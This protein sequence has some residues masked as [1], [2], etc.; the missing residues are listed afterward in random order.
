LLIF[1]RGPEG[2]RIDYTARYQNQAESIVLDVPEITKAFSVVALGIGTPGVVNEGAFFTTLRPWEERER[3]QQEIASELRDKLWNVPGITAYPVNP[4]PLSQSFRSSPISLVI[5]GPDVAALAHYA[6][7]IVNRAGDIPGVV[8]P[9][10]DLLL[11]KPQLEVRIDRDRASDLG[12]SVREVASTLQILLGGLDLS[13]FK[14]EG[15]IYDVIAQLERPARSSPRSVLGLYAHGTGGQLVPMVSLVNV[16][17]A[18]APRALPHFDRLRAATVTAGVKEG[19]VLGSVLG[20]VRALADEVLPEGRG[21]R[22]SFSGES[23]DFYESG[24]AIVFAYVL[25]VAIIFLVLSAQFESFLHP[26]TILIAV[27]LSFTGALVALILSGATLNLFSQIGLVMLVGLVTKNSILIVEFA[28]QLRGRGRSV[29]EAVFEAARTRFRPILMTAIST[30]VGILPIALGWG[31]GGESRAPLGIAVVGGMFFS[32]LLT[33]FVVPAAYILVDRAR[34][35]VSG[36]RQTG[37]GVPP[38]AAGQR[39]A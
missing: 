14:H 35:A 5:Q 37:A 33:I 29:S 2:T 25:A 23:E 8:N 10:T 39:R 22:T 28:N 4:S 7:E 21:F 27:A 31:A 32:T 36:L 38:T 26:L 11:N 13:T 19:Y 9:R 3:S 20:Q 15:E 34:V 24:N 18:T 17:E 6:D 1:T 12:V 16:T 30:I